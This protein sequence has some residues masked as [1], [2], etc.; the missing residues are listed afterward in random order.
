MIVTIGLEIESILHS[1]GFE[2]EMNFTSFECL[3]VRYNL[4]VCWLNTITLM[5][6]KLSPFWEKNNF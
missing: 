1:K 2:Y 5:Q 4:H 3:H 6:N